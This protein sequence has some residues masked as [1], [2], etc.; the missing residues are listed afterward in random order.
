[1]KS[2]FSKPQR[3]SLVGVVVMFADTFQGAIRALWPILIVWIFR[4]KELNKLSVLA[5][6]GVIIVLVGII[7]YLK[8]LNFTFFLDEKNEEFVIRKGILNKSRLAIPLDKIQQVNIN[9]SLI[10]RIINV[11]A[12]E[13]DTA[14]SSKKEVSIRAIDHNLALLLKERLLENENEVTENSDIFGEGELKIRQNEKEYPFIQISFIT[15]LKTGITSNYTRSFALLFA[16]FISIYQYIEDIVEATGYEEDPL[17]EYINA[18]LFLRFITTIIIIILVLTLV[19]NLL[20]TIIK[21]FDFKIT[22]KQNSLLLSFGLINTKSTIIRPEK[23][24]I[25][26]VG[27][28]FF[29]KKL[30]I[31]DIRIRQAYNQTS[32][33]DHLKSAIEIPG[34]NDNEKDAL[35]QFLLGKIPEKG[36][37][38]KPNIRKVL[39][40]IVKA[41]LIPSGIYFFLVYLSPEMIDYVMFLAVYIL[42]VS[43]I[44]FFSFRNYKLFVNND[45]IIKQSG[46]WD[47]STEILAPHKI[48]GVSLTQYFWH[49]N[50]DIG[51]VTLHTAGG[52]LTFGLTGYTKLKELVN[53]WL[54]QVETTNKNWM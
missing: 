11:Y 15:L 39:F 17:K 8:Y 26:A 7:A 46:A 42:F 3:Q 28:N 37:G 33:K 31:Q 1:M 34:C 54:Y 43:I 38:L 20:R 30:E 14:G 50:P 4:F 23:V 5:G 13:V 29:Q 21:Y 6:A 41:I 27:R 51:I 12:L 52:N 44:I 2:D 35:M 9:Q 10:Q 36:L 45:F 24:Q 53:Y 16:F 25:L 18:E 47:I 40:Q 22:R 48:Q 19:V 32:N 49:K